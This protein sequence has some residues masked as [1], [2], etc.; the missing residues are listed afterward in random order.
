MPTIGPFL[1]L[2]EQTANVTVAN[3]TTETTLVGTGNGS[4]TLPVN[5][6]QFGTAMQLWAMG[7][8]STTVGPTPTLRIRVKL[9]AAIVL[10]TTATTLTHGID[11]L[12]WSC[13]AL[14]VCRA[15]GLPGSVIANGEM[16][17][18]LGLGTTDQT[19]FFTPNIVP[20]SVA[21]TGQLLFNVTAQWGTAN[22][23]N[24]IT[25]VNLSISA[26]LPV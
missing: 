10:D 18:S 2:F 12:L 17:Y 14:F 22:I 4:A 23:R 26:T 7:V 15:T 13:H 8:Y 5:F 9:G 19:D 20:I 1:S 21:T 6:L 16:R 24:T 3:T 11:T 25:A